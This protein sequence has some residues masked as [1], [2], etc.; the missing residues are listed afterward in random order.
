MN[1]IKSAAVASAAL[2]I[3]APQASAAPFEFAGFYA[4]VHG[5]YVDSTADFSS[6]NLTDDGSLGGVQAGY[7][8]L[9]GN[10]L[11]GVETDISLSNADPSGACPDNGAFSCEVESGPMAT[12]R[13]RVGYAVDDWLIYV[14]GGAAGSRFELDTD[15]PGGRNNGLFG[16]TVGAGAE[17]LVGD[18]VGV[19]L[20]Y[21]YLQFGDFERD[22]ED[23]TGADI[24]VN[25]HVIMGGINF[26]F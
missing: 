7:N 15:G 11:Y 23:A 2:L 18:I 8:F 26:H 17:Y 19:K 5:G 16:W 25:M 20:E 14:T 1:L 24:D 21:R 12:L 22:L 6:G 10:F 13:A 3:A 4:G 9:S